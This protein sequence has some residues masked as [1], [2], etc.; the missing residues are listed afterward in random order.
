M[1]PHQLEQKESDARRDAKELGL[2]LLLAIRSKRADAVEMIGWDAATGRFRYKGRLVPAES[3]RKYLARIESRFRG[4]LIKLMVDLQSGTI[5]VAQWHREFERMVSSTHILSG[6]LALG[7]IAVA[8][9]NENVVARL[10]SELK[11]ADRFADDLRAGRA[12]SVPAARARAASYLMKGHIT[13]YFVEQMARQAVGLQ[14]Q[15][16]RVRTASESCVGCIYWSKQ[17][18]LPIKEM[19]PIGSLDCGGFCRCILIYR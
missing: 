1:T 9:R 14:K 17:G 10:E 15:C 4:R 3:V 19:P 7:G 5:S 11:Y 6:A 2:L 16:K 13:F 8:M 12:G 18:W